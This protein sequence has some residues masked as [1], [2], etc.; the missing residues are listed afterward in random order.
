MFFQVLSSIAWH[1]KLPENEW[2]FLDA[3][4]TR[5]SALAKHAILFL[6]ALESI[7][8]CYGYDTFGKWKTRFSWAL[9]Q[10]RYQFWFQFHV[11]KRIDKL[12]MCCSFFSRFS[13]HLFQQLLYL[14]WKSSDDRFVARQ[15]LEDL[16][17]FVFI[18]VAAFQ[19]INVVLMRIHKIF[20]R[21][22]F[23]FID[24]FEAEQCVIATMN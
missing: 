12:R 23:R 19:L 17:L 24:C 15:K 11:R 16:L 18:A 4:W 20:D 7:Y 6:N 9:H 8:I 14:I 2:I 3:K 22:D 10:I 13:V 21:F 5:E 1:P